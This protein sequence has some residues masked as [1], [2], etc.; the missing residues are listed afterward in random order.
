MCSA[1]VVSM[2]SN[3]GVSTACA[4][5]GRSRSGGVNVVLDA[6]SR[7]HLPLENNEAFFLFMFCYF[8]GRIVFG[9]DHRLGLIGAGSRVD[10][11]GFDLDESLFTQFCHVRARSRLQFLQIDGL[12]NSLVNILQ[13]RSAGLRMRL[14]LQNKKPL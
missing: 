11:A 1:S 7:K 13:G 4:Q 9:N 10:I 14:D 8:G 5:S 12:A 2:T 3:I 6:A